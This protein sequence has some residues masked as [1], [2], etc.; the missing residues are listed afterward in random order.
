MMS[1]GA[2][3]AEG[4]FA[5]AV[6]LEDAG[7][8]WVVAMLICEFSRIFTCKNGCTADACEQ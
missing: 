1:S 8:C 6:A 7:T 4:G 3:A 2:E 5:E